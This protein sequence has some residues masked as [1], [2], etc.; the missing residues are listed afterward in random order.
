MERFGIKVICNDIVTCILNG[1]H[2]NTVDPQITTSL[3][4]RPLVLQSA[5]EV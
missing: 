3:T 5:E 4:D 2:L 1:I